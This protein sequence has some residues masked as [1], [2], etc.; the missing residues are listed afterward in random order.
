MA[1]VPPPKNKKKRAVESLATNQDT[2]TGFGDLRA[3][4]NSS[5]LVKDVRN[6]KRFYVWLIS[7]GP[8]HHLEDSTQC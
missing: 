7:A 2:P 6:D 8:D 3:K 1:L 4:Q 5:K